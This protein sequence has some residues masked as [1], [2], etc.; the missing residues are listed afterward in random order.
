MVDGSDNFPKVFSN[1]KE[2]MSSSVG[3]QSFLFVTCGDWDLKQMLPQQCQREQIDLPPYFR[4]WMNIKKV[5][6]YLHI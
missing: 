5:C 4:T 2:W 3:D 6:N 1:F